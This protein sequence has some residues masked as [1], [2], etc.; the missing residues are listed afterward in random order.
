MYKVWLIQNVIAPYRIRLFE[1]IANHTNFDFS[2]VLTAPACSH[3]PHWRFDTE[4]LPFKVRTMHGFNARFLQGGSLSLS[5]GLLFSLFWH[6]PNVVICNGFGLSTLLVYIYTRVFRRKYIVWTESTPIT[7]KLRGLG[8]MRKRL[9]R[10]LAAH[11]EAFIDAGTQA[12]EYIHTLIRKKQHVLTFRSFNCVDGSLFTLALPDDPRIPSES[13]KRNRRSRRRILFV[14]SLNERKGIPMLLDVY[15]DIVLRDM[16]DLGLVLIGEGPL[17]D[18][19]GQFK[20]KHGLHEIRIGGQVPYAQTA[21]WYKA[22]DVFMLLSLWD[23]N[24]L[25]VFE[26]LHAGLPI[27]CTNRAGN[28]VD[29]I[30]AGENGFIVDPTNKDEIVR[31]TIEVLCWNSA[32]RTACSQFSK[33]IVK[34]ANYRDSAQ[35]FIDAC[36]TIM[37][38][39][40]SASD[41]DRDEL[42]LE[43]AP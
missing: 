10:F 18:Y 35:A 22:C 1:E 31:R 14:G 17:Q 8:P 3:R 32:K 12:R 7:E 24:P 16:P 23:C 21:Q 15:R 25:V 26:A 20:T 9:R 36:H 11:T 27:I 30:G 41:E 34:K 6:R 43:V 19:V 38:P 2:V 39:Q 29:F 13:N 33:H 4:S 42:D 5:Y 40:V 37:R 28:A